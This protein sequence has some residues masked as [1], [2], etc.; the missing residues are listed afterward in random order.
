MPPCYLTDL[1]FQ[2]MVE[3]IQDPQSYLSAWELWMRI[4]NIYSPLYDWIIARE[5][6]YI[7][8]SIHGQ[9]IPGIQVT[10]RSYFGPVQL[11][12]M[13]LEHNDVAGMQ[14]HRKFEEEARDMLLYYINEYL[15]L[16][17][18]TPRVFAVA[19]ELA[20]IFYEWSGL[21]AGRAGNLT[22]LTATDVDGKQYSGTLHV[23]DDADA[24]HLM[25]QR[26]HTFDPSGVGR[27]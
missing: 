1:R 9:S 6:C 27:R 15:Y 22:K 26:V 17:I 25:L 3:K 8:S 10:D 18:K 12:L 14:R 4:L 21:A 11:M 5:R 13:P 7:P 20:I 2:D 19:S 23:V 24:V 16:P